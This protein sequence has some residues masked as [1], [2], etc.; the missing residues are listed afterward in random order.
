MLQLSFHNYKIFATLFSE[1]EFRVTCVISRTYKSETPFTQQSISFCNDANIC[2]ICSPFTRYGCSKDNMRG[3][4][5][6]T[7]PDR[8]VLFKRKS[9]PYNFLPNKNW[10]GSV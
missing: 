2:H 4:W 6:K 9:Y 10:P 8:V 3:R 1:F 7:C 5:S